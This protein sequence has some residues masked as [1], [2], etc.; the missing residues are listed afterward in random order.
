MKDKFS[1]YFT[2]E[3]ALLLPVVFSIIIFVIY[4]SF[5]QYNRCLLDEETITIMVRG[6][7]PA[8]S[9]KAQEQINSLI[10]KEN[11][12][13][14]NKFILFFNRKTETEKEGKTIQIREEGTMNA[15]YQENISAEVP[16]K[17]WRISS[18]R[19]VEIYDPSGFLMKCRKAEYFAD[20]ILE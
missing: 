18:G 10:Q 16:K 5:F 8:Y 2:I 15:F 6:S 4:L 20:R 14:K 9:E 7:N 17:T 3:A 12:E 19:Q 1:G 11:K 13:S